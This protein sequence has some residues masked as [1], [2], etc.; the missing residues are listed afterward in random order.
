M[1]GLEHEARWFVDSYPSQSMGQFCPS[2]LLFYF[3]TSCRSPG[4]RK[5][6]RTVGAHSL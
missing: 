1:A 4:E 3:H 6:T 2:S 5:R